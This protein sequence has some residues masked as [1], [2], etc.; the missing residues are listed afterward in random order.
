MRLLKAC[1]KYFNALNQLQKIIF[2]CFFKQDYI[3]NYYFYE[4][5]IHKARL[6]LFR[7]IKKIRGLATKDNP[8][9]LAKLENLYEIIFSLDTLKLRVAD[10]ATFEMCEMEF[11][12]LSACLSNTLEYINLFLDKQQHV[13]SDLD[14]IAKMMGK[15]SHQIDALEELYRSTL[16]VVAK[17]P[18]FFLFF[19]QDLMAFRDELESFL[20]ELFNDQ[21]IKN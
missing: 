13:H 6:K 16:Q 1:I 12:K 11:K 9:N 19:V 18:I 7:A 17:D 21:S 2:S 3:V 4:Q 14:N 20:L 15:L 8:V 5:K 10:H